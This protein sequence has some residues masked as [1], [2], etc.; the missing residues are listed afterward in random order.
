MKKAEMEMHDAEY[1]QRLAVAK[2]AESDGNF[3]EAMEAAISAWEHIDGMMQFQSKYE[4]EK[5]ESVAAIDIV[6]RYAPL[7]LEFQKL[8]TLEQ[9][10]G[11][12][13]RIERNTT[14]SPREKLEKARAEMRDNYR[15]LSYI[16]K[17]PDTSQEQFPKEISGSMTSWP[18]S[19]EAWI[20]MGYLQ[21]SSDGSRYR[22]TTRMEDRVP[23]KCTSCGR[24]VEGP[25]RVLLNNATCPK[26]KSKVT[27][28]LLSTQHN[29]S[30]E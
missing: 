1:R 28:V 14:V 27:F 6:L 13:R 11:N 25:K 21:R 3:P 5:V 16:E 4:D 20:A 2:Y 24:V 30:R 23:A 22:L 29:H 17:H 10:L 12:C 8:D 26:C 9:F 15:L 18:L 19:L 7:L